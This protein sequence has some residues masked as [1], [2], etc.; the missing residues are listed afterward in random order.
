MWRALAIVAVLGATARADDTRTEIVL[1]D[2]A[3]DT[4]MIGRV[5]K[6]GVHEDVDEAM[7]V[8]LF[9]HV[10]GAPIVH[11]AHGEWGTAGVDLGVRA[12]VP[13]A[14]WF[15]GDLA[16]DRW[17]LDSPYHDFDHCF[18]LATTGGFAGALAAQ[19]FDWAVLSR[20]DQPRSVMLSFGAHF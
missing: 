2:A 12:L 20:P 18:W 6:D 14:G 19:V 7:A 11:A 5:G 17:R 8:G 16:C 9:L 10:L 1:G 4:M 3:A 15:A 13:T